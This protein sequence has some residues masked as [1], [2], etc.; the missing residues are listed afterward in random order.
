MK[1]SEMDETL[2]YVRDLETGNHGV[3]FYRGPHEKRKVL[4]NYLQ[5][6]FQRGEGAIYVATQETPT[7]IRRHMEDFGMN[8]KT[9]ERDGLLRIF[10][11]EDWYIFDG[12][13]DGSRTL[14]LAKQVFD[15][16]M[17]IG[18]KGLRA[19]GEAACFFE[20]HKEKELVEFELMIGRKLNIPVTALCAYDV[21]HVKS[22][23][24]QSFFSL[25]QAHG[26]VVTST[27]AQEVR[28]QRVFPAITYEVVED[29]FGE[30]GKKTILRMLKDQSSFT[31]QKIGEDPNCFIQRL[32]QLLGSGAQVITKT[33]ATRMQT[34]MGI[35]Q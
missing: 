23:E 34:R 8:V 9:L 12:Q 25:I 20:R 16:T 28:F 33:V 32:N 3:F 27:F 7:Q 21:N 4:F 2:N 15:E 6:G 1:A 13:V 14:L 17:A 29:V 18:L 5:S 22:L 31:P 26:P 19:C 30:T 35:T 10:D 11:C 24:E